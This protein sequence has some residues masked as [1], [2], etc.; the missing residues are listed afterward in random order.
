M[1]S[2]VYQSD[3]ITVTLTVNIYWWWLLFISLTTLQYHWLSTS[4]DGESCLSV[5]LHYSTTDCQ[6]LLMASLVYQSDYITVTLTVNIYW[7]RVLFISLTT[8]QYHW[9]STSTDGESCLSVWLHYSNT[10]CQHL[11]MASLVYQSD[12]ITVTLTVNIYWWRV[13]FISLTTLQ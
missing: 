4:I 11:L 5:W 10:D 1:A 8:L 13:L 6:H 9:L 2:L 7:W 12:Y 3:Y